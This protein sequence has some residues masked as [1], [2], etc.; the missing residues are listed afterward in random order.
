MTADWENGLLQIEKGTFSADTF[1]AGIAQMVRDLIASAP[2]PTAEQLR[3]FSS[4]VKTKD[5]IGVCPW[6]GSEEYDGK[7][8]YY[9]SNRECR[10]C[11]W[12][13]NKF[14]ESLKQPMTKSWRR[15]CS[16]K[17]VSTARNCIPNVPGKYLR[18]ILS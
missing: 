18:Q 1:I 16:K 9:C 4:S 14:L 10:F 15:N 3:L 11:L 12:K 8:S 17:V 2:S 5:S 13:K 7:S 6:C